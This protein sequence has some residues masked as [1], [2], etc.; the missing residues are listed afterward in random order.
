[1]TAVAARITRLQAGNPGDCKS[2]GK[3]VFELRI[4]KGPG[5]RIY[6]GK[7]VKSIVLLLSGGNKGAQKRDITKAHEYWK[8]YKSRR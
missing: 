4:D 2:V 3:G 7:E 8:D 5:Y 6:I 1:M